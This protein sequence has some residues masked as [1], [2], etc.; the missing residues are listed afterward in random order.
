MLLLPAATG[1]RKDNLRE[2]EQKRIKRG[3]LGIISSKYRIYSA[4]LHT[5][6]RFLNRGNS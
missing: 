3:H 5:L 2:Q 1:W 6:K 4:L